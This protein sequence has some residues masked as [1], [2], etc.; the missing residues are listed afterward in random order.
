MARYSKGKIAILAYAPLGVESLMLTYLLSDYP[1]LAR[2]AAGRTKATRLDVRACRR[3][4]ALA[5]ASDLGAMGP[6][7]RGLYDSLAASEPVPG[8]GRPIAAL[9]AQVRA[10]GFRRMTDEKA[11]MDELSGEPDMVPGPFRVKCLLCGDV[12]ESWYRDCPAPAKARIGMAS[13]ACGNVSADSMGFLGYGRILS[14]QPDSF[15][16]LDLA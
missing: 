14:R 6:E 4:Y 5:T 2:L 12:A 10:D 1:V 7:E 16:V 8:S 15:E 9:Q 3:L 11:F 13:C